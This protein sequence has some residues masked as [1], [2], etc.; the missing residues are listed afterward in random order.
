MTQAK[1]LGTATQKRF[2]ERLA[3]GQLSSS[4]SALT[5]NDYLDLAVCGGYPEMAMAKH[6]DVARQAWY[7]SYLR[8]VATRDAK[9]LPPR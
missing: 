9:A 2:V 3:E 8:S 5:V 6:G 4:A 7:S 1:I